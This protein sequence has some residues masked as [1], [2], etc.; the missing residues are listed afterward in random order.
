MKEFLLENLFWIVLIVVLLMVIAKYKYD[1]FAKARAQRKRFARGVKAESD[2]GHFLKSRGFEI[3][4]TQSINYH[5]Y[6]IE[7]E[8]KTAKLM[9][10]FVVGKAGK[11]FLVEVKSG[12]SAILIENK[13]TRRQILE[14]DY[15]IEN[16]GVFLLDMENKNLKRIEFSYRNT[17]K[18]KRSAKSDL[19]YRLFLVLLICGASAAPTWNGKSVFIALGVIAIAFPNTFNKL[20]NSFSG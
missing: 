19:Y 18:S 14:Y 11:V 2:A 9:V 4:E 17:T 13:D 12:T 8:T 16:D 6:K 1:A 10:D 20:F 5:T 3:L 15:A 7:G